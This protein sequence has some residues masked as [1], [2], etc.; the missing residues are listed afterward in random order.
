MDISEEQ[1]PRQIT[2]QSEW[3]HFTADPASKIRVWNKM[4]NDEDFMRHMYS[5]W[6]HW[7]EYTKE[8]VRRRTKALMKTMILRACGYVATDFKDFANPW[9]RGLT[10]DKRC[11]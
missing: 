9:H 8:D 7:D 2:H 1:S 3:Y 10:S 5:M 6:R 4:L 11:L